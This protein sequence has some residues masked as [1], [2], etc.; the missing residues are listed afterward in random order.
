MKCCPIWI[1]LCLVV[2]RVFGRVFRGLHDRRQRGQSHAG[3][4]IARIGDPQEASEAA[5]FA[6]HH[7]TETVAVIFLHAEND[8]RIE[9]R[10]GKSQP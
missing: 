1:A 6:V 3:G 4:A 10:I 5:D 9:K 2:G 7:D 8:Q